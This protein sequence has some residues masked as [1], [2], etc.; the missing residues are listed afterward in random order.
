MKKVLFLILTMSSLAS[1]TSP[2]LSM[3]SKRAPRAFGLLAGHGLAVAGVKKLEEKLAVNVLNNAANGI[4]AMLD[5]V[6]NNNERAANR[7][8]TGMRLRAYGL[9]CLGRLKRV[10]F[11]RGAGLTV[12]HIANNKLIDSI[13]RWVP[14]VALPTSLG[15]YA[16]SSL[17]GCNWMSEKVVD[18]PYLESAAWAFAAGCLGFNKYNK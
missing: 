5:A 6:M 18:N 15:M 3:A 17:P 7:W 1:A 13:G 10:L 8:L 14:F 16:I 11:M 12:G 4:G 2:W 9:L